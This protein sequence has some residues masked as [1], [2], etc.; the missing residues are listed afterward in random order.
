MVQLHR[1]FHL[2]AEVH[3]QCERLSC[4]FARILQQDPERA[5]GVG[6]HVGD[7]ATSALNRPRPPQ[8]AGRLRVGWYGESGPLTACGAALSSTSGRL[9]VTLGP[10]V[11]TDAGVL[12]EAPSVT[13]TGTTLSSFNAPCTLLVV[14]GPPPLR[15]GDVPILF[16]AVST[17]GGRRPETR[18]AR[19][20][21]DSPAPRLPA[22]R[23][24]GSGTHPESGSSP[25][26]RPSRSTRPGSCAGT[27]GGR[28]P[29]RSWTDPR[30]AVGTESGEVGT[31][32]C[33]PLQ[34]RRGPERRARRQAPQSVGARPRSTPRPRWRLDP[35]RTPSLDERDRAGS[36]SAGSVGGGVA[37]RSAGDQTPLER[38]GGWHTPRARLSSRWRR[39]PSWSVSSARTRR[40]STSP[41]AH[42]SCS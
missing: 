15:E 26:S 38:R 5:R 11:V 6:Y 30:R 20:G 2:P 41:S 10:L 23:Y 31:A 4:S 34:D 33:S 17:S 35:L 9:V 21:N 37:R 16:V 1:P 40:R 36:A 18:P 12:V 22:P 27:A 8:R 28:G 32:T 3:E 25:P 7:G 24:E 13:S 19:V 14:D 39:E 42:G 29:T